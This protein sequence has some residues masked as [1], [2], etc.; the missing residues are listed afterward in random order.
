VISLEGRPELIVT[1]VTQIRYDASAGVSYAEALQQLLDRS[2]DVLHAGEIRDQATAR[3][4]LRVAVTGRKV[5]ATVH[6][7]D[8]VSGVRRL[9]DMGLAP[10][11]LA[12]SLHAVVSLRL[13]RR[14]CVKCARPFDAEKD[15]KSREARL[16]AGLGVQP[17]KMPVGCKFCA[18]TGYMNQIPVP[19]V[20]VMTPALRDVLAAGPSDAELV[21]AARAEGMRSFA[22][23]GGERVTK[24]ET[25]VEELE[26]V[27]GVVPSREE[28]A[29]S[30]GAVLVVEDEPQ[31]R[32]LLSNV[33]RGM[34]FRVL[35]AGD[36]SAAQQHLGS[37]EELSLVLLD[38]F[39]PGDDGRTLLRGIRRSL[40]TQS[41]PIIIVTS[42]EDPRHEFELLDAGADDYI[43][44]P[45][46]M[47]QL[48]ARVRAVLRR[49]GVRLVSGAQETPSVPEPRKSTSSASEPA[50]IPQSAGE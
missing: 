44:K 41:L 23:I 36:A 18:G 15:G 16:A 25:T 28:A 40:A 20:L 32:L 9:L 5:L 39:L 29:G 4:V 50:G 11:R 10:G 49:A 24:G 8:A 43:R 47:E 22:E 14:L 46:V 38:L 27:L 34:G 33:L 1:G 31:D 17:L 3:I 21:R 13:V 19:E 35:E 30:V 42:S 45:L 37:G 26:R 6:T 2:P 48:Q 12:E 7:S